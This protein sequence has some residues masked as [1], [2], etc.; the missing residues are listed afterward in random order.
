MTRD[1]SLFYITNP[2]GRVSLAHATEVFNSVRY[3]HT[4]EHPEDGERFVTFTLWD[5]DNL[6]N[7]D[8]SFAARAEITVV[9]VND[10]PVAM[11]DGEVLVAPG[12]AHLL[13][14]IAN[15]IDVDLHGVSIVGVPTASQGTVVVQSDSTLVYTP[16]ASFSGTDTITYTIQD[17]VGATSSA[18]LVV[19]DSA[20]N[21]APS[22]GLDQTVPGLEESPAGTVVAALGASDPDAADALIYRIVQDTS[23]GLFDLSGDDLVVRS[24]RT[25]PNFD[26][27]GNRTWQ[28]TV[29]VTDPQADADVS[30]ITI[31]LVDVFEESFGTN[32]G[33]VI[34]DLGDAGDTIIGLNGDDVIT[35]E[36]GDNIIHGDS[37]VVV[38]IDTLE[39]PEHATEGTVL[40]TLSAS[41]ATGDVTFSLLNDPLGLFDVDGD[42]LVVAAGAVLPNLDVQ[43]GFVR[44]TV[45]ATD[46]V[47]THSGSFVGTLL[48][49]FEVN[50]GTD[51]NNTIRDL[52]NAGDTVEGL[53]GNDNLTGDAGDGI[54]DGGN[55][56]DVIRGGVGADTLLGG[57][58]NDLIFVDED[59]V[60]V[61][62]GVG[63]DTL[64][65]NVNSR[66]VDW[67]TT[68][69]LNFERF[70]GSAYADTIDDSGDAT[71]DW[72]YGFDGEDT[73]TGGAGNDR[74]W[75]YD[76]NDTLDGGAGNDD[77]RGLHGDDV[78]VGGD[79]NDVLRGGHGA[80]EFDGGPGN[81]TIADYHLQ[82]DISLDAGPGVDTLTFD[83]ASVVG[84]L[85][86]DALQVESINA[87]DITTD[88]VF[89]GSAV[90]G[91]R[92][93][94]N[95]GQGN[96]TLIGSVL[97]D[98]LRGRD[99]DD[100][101]QGGDGADTLEG[102]RGAD[103]LIGG[104]GNDALWSDSSDILIDGGEG[105]DIL[106][107][108]PQSGNV[109]IDLGASG[110]E[111]I[112]N[113]VSV[114]DRGPGNDT[115]DA[116][117]AAV[118]TDIYA[119]WGD[120][121]LIG[122][123]FN[124]VL[125]GQDGDDTIVGGPGNDTIVGAEGADA[126]SGGI[127]NDRF[128]TVNIKEGDT[129]NGGD[130]TD[131]VV[132]AIQTDD[133]TVDFS[134]MEVEVIETGGVGDD[135][136][137]A[138]GKT[139]IRVNVGNAGTGEDTF[140]GSELND[141]FQGR[142]DNDLIEGNGGGDNL[143]GQGGDDILRG[144]DG[145]DILYGDNVV[146]T[147]IHHVAGDDI[148]E[149]G[150]GNDSLIGGAG[151]DQLIGGAGNDTHLGADGNDTS[152]FSGPI[153]DYSFAV[154]GND[155]RVTDS[156]SARDGVDAVEMY[157]VENLQFSD[158]LVTPSDV[159]DMRFDNIAVSELA[160]VGDSAG[161]VT[162]NT[163]LTGTPVWSLTN[164]GGGRFAIDDASGELS[165]VDDS[166]L[167]AE[168]L[169]GLRNGNPL[170][171][172][173]VQV[174]DGTS[175]VSQRI[176]VRFTDV[177]E[178]IEGGS[179]VD[180]LVDRGNAG[181]T[182]RGF[183]GNDDLRGDFG[184]NLIEGGDGADR[185]FGLAGDDTV[186]GD[187]GNDDVFGH[188]GNDTL[189]G[190]TGS[191]DL[192]GHDGNDTLDGGEG[193]DT[194]TGGSGADVFIGG[195]GDDTV[196]DFNPDAGDTVSMGDGI[197]TLIYDRSHASI[198][199]DQ[200]MFTDVENARGTRNDDTLDWS[201]QTTTRTLMY[202]Y[203]GNDTLTGTDFNATDQLFGGEGDDTIFAGAGNDIL[204]GG[205]SGAL[206]SGDDVLH[207]EDGND[208]IH[209][210]AGDDLLFGGPGADT[211]NG[212][213]GN[214]N[215]D[216]GADNDNLYGHAGS[217]S[218]SGGDGDDIIRDYQ[219]GIDKGANGVGVASDL[220]GG[221]GVDRLI[222]QVDTEVD[223]TLDL[224][225]HSIERVDSQGGNDVLDG[226]AV[227]TNNITL[228][229]NDG[230]DTLVG[231]QL[232]DVLDGGDDNDTITGGDGN[233]TITGGHGADSLDGGNGND[234]FIN[235]DNTDILLDGGAGFDWLRVDPRSGDVVVDMTAQGIEQVETGHG[236]R[237]DDVY[238]ATGKI[239]FDIRV[240]AGWGDDTVIGGALNDV[241][242]GEE[243]DDSLTGG[244]GN[245]ILNGG[246]GK[247]S[248]IGGAGNDT[249]QDL[250]SEDT[251]IDLGDGIDTVVVA[252]DSDAVNVDLTAT[253]IER[254]TGSINDDVFD[255]SAKT[256][257]LILTGHYGDDV[258]SGGS[259][260]DIII[261]SWGNDIVDGGDGIDEV[262][263]QGL[264][265]DYQITD[266]GNG[267][268]TVIDAVANRDGVNIVNN[269]ENIRFIAQNRVAP[270]ATAVTEITAEGD[271]QIFGGNG[272]DQLFGNGANDLLN[273]N[274]G[275]DFLTGGT[276]AD[277]HIGGGGFDTSIFTGDFVD[278]L[279][280]YNSDGTITVQDL[281][282]GRD[283]TDTVSCDVE[284]LQFADQ[285]VPTS[286]ICVD[287]SVITA[288]DAAPDAV[289]GV[290]LESDLV[291]QYN[292]PGLGE[293]LVSTFGVIG[294]TNID[295]FE[296]TTTNGPSL[297][298]FS[299]LDSAS[300]GS[301]LVVSS[302]IGTL[303]I[304]G[305][306]ATLSEVMYQYTLDA[307]QHHSGSGVQDLVTIAVTDLNG[308]VATG[309]LRFE[310]VD[311]D[312]DRDGISNFLD[313]DDDNDG[314]TDIEEFDV[315]EGS[316]LDAT[317]N[318]NS[319]A[320]LSIG[321][322]DVE[323]SNDG[324]INFQANSTGMLLNGGSATANQ[325]T[326]SFLNPVESFSLTIN[327]L[328]TSIESMG[329]FSVVPTSV[330]GEM[331]LIGSGA[332]T[333]V[334]GV[335]NNS[336]GVVTWDNLSGVSSITYTHRR[337]STGAGVF[338][339]DAS[340]SV[341][342]DSDNDGV[343]NH[344]D[345]DSDNDGITDNVEAQYT[346]SYVAPSGMGG[347]PAF[348]D[349]DQ[350]GLDG[351]YDAD[352][353][354]ADI[355]NGDFSDGLN[356]WN[357]SGVVT[358]LGTAPNQ[359]LV[360]NGGNLAA[361]GVVT[362]V[363]N[364]VVGET[365]DVGYDIFRNGS[366]TVSVTVE[367]V[368]TGNLAV[369]GS[370]AATTS[371]S[372][373]ATQ[374]FQFIAAST[375]TEIRIV[376]TTANSINVD[377]NIDNLTISNTTL[378][379]ANNLI[380][381][382][383]D[384][385]G[386]PDYLD[387]DS[388]G[389][390]VFDAVE[391]GHGVLQADIDLN[392]DADFDGL[393]DEVEGSNAADGFYVNDE[394]RDA[395]SI[396]LADSD[397]DLL[398]DGTN[399]VP[400][401]IDSDFREALDSDGDN[402]HDAQDMD[403]DNDGILDIVENTSSS[404]IVNP[405]AGER[406]DFML[407]GVAN[408]V[409]FS[410][411]NGG[412]LSSDSD[413]FAYAEGPPAVVG[414]TY[415]F[416]FDTPVDEVELAFAS[417][418]QD[419]PVGN[420]IVT[421]SDGVVVQNL[422]VSIAPL[423]TATGLP[424][425]NTVVKII[426][427]T[428][429][430]IT[431]SI[432]NNGTGNGAQGSG[433]ITL[434]G[435]DQSKTIESVSWDMLGDR[436]NTASGLVLPLVRTFTDSD[437]DG[438]PNFLDLDSDN[439]GI[440]DLNESGFTNVLADANND[441]TVSLAESGLFVGGAGDAVGVDGL[442]DVFA[443]TT[444]T[445]PRDSESTPDAIVD[446]VDLD[447]DGDSI[448]DATEARATGDYIAY[449]ATIDAAADTDRDGI[450]DVFDTNPLFGS[451]D[452]SFKS[453]TNTAYAHSD[454]TADTTPDY[455]DTDSDGDGIDDSIEA[456]TIATAPSFSDP[457]GSVN[458]P[459]TG[460]LRNTDSASDVDFRN[461]DA[462]NDGIPDSVEGTADTDGDGTPNYLDTDSDGD[463]IDD[464]IETIVDTDGDGLPDYLDLDSD[465]DGL[466]DFDEGI[467]DA[468][469]DG[470]A[471][472]LQPI[473][474]D[475]DGIGDIFDIDD[476]NDGILDV[477]E[478]DAGSLVVHHT[479][480]TRGD[481]MFNGV[482]NGVEFS[483]PNGGL[484]N[485]DSGFF[486]FREGTPASIGSIYEFA[487]DNPVDEVEL[488]F[489][490]SAE[491]AP[492]GNFTVTYSD[493]VV[494]PNLDV[495]VASLP[496]DSPLPAGDTFVKNVT[497]TTI[498][499]M[500][501]VPGND[502]TVFQQGSG[503]ITLRGLDPSKTI[504][505]ISWELLGVHSIGED[506]IV[507]PIVRSFVDSDADGVTDDRD[508]DSDNDGITDN[509]EA[510]LTAGYVAPSGVGGT[511]DFLDAN[512]DGLD[513][514][515][516]SAGT[517]AG[518]TPVDTDS[519]ASDADGI[520][521]YFDTDS[522]NDGIAD[523]VEAGVLAA[524][525]P[526]QLTNT[527][528]T[529][530]VDFRDLDTDNDGILDAVEGVLDTDGDGVSNYQDTDSDNDG[531]SDSI[532]GVND[533][534]L[535]GTPDYLDTDSDGDGIADVFEMNT[536]SDGD[537]TPDYL[538]TDSDN[539][540]INDIDEDVMSPTLLGTDSDNDGIDDA[541][542]VDVTGGTDADGNGIDDDFEPTDTDG[543]GT[544][545]HI[546]PDSDGDGIA[547][548]LEGT[549]D[550]DGDGT[551]DYL[552]TD[553]DNDGIADADEDTTSPILLGTDADNDGIDDAL[554]V[555][556]TG[557]T[558]AD[559]NGI[560]DALEPTD[561][562]ADGTPDHL[563]PDSDDDGIADIIEGSG[564]TDGDGIPDYLDSDSD[565]DGIS[566][567][568]EDTTSPTL[569]GTDA[570]NDGIDDAI[571]VD[572]TGGAD[573]DGNG[574]DDALEPTDTDGDGVPDHID[575][576]SDGDGIADIIEGV[577]DNDGDGI[578]D[579]LDSDSDNDG[580]ADAEEDSASPTLLGT[581]ADSDGIDD[582][583][584]VDLTGGTDA[585]GNGIDDDF[586]PTDTDGDGTPDHLDPD[587]DGDGIADIF[588]GGGDTDGDGTPDYQDTDSDNDGIAD[589]DEDVTSPTL[590]GADAD[591]DG[592]DDAI[593]VDV[594]GG[595]D[596]DGNGIDDVFEP[597]DSDGDGTPDHIDPDSD[598]DGIADI[599]EGAG[600]A[601]GDGILD[602]LDTDSDNDGIGDGDEDNTSPALLGTDA[603][604]DGIDDALDV[605][606]SGGVDA[607]GNGIDD[608]LE[609]TDT[610][611]D[612]IADHIDP[613]S[614][615]DGIADIFEGSGDTDG[616]GTPDYQDTDSDND[617]IVDADEDTT[618]PTLSGT[619][620]DNDGIDDAIDVDVTGGTDTDGNGIDDALEPTDTDGDGVPDYIDPD[621]DGDGIADI[622]EGN[623]DTDGDGIPDYLDND[624][625]NDGISDA[626]EDTTSPALLGTDAD[627]DG[628][629]DAIDVDVTGGTDADGNGI[630][631]ALE[632]TDTDGDGV[633]DHIDPDSDGDGIDDVVEGDV[634]TDGDGIRDSLDP[635]SDNDG[636][637]DVL[638]AALDTDNDGIPNYID[639][640]S[641]GDGLSDTLEAATDP[642]NPL[643]TDSDGIPDF[644]DPDSDNDGIPDVL[645]GMVDTD[646]DGIP[647]SQDLDV[648][649]DG[650]GD[651]LEAG[652]D[653][654]NPVDTD[655]DG[656]PD[657]RDL[658]SDG[659]G[660][661]D[662]QEASD[663][664]SDP[665]DS[666]GDGIRDFR[667]IDS[668]NDGLTDEEEIG[669]DPLNPLDSN[670]DGIPDFQEALIPEP[671][672]SDG[673]GIPDFVEGT[674]D[675]DGDGVPDA[676]DTD[677]DN[678]GLPD[679]LE[680]GH[681][682]SNPLDS[683]GDGIPDY[684]DLDSD[685][686][687]MT[688]LFEAGGVDAD[689]NGLIDDFIDT[690]G[691][692]GDDNP[693]ATPVIAW[694]SDGDGIADYLDLDS[695]NDGL[696]DVWESVGPSADLDLDG[697]LDNMIDSNGDG[698][699]DNVIVN[700]VRDTDNDGEPN[701]LDIDSD[702]DGLFDIVEAGGEDLN[703][704]G[705]VDAWTDSDEDG[706]PD[707]V[708]V[709][710]TGG[711]DQDGDGI[712]DFYDADFINEP[713]SDGDGIVD[714]FDEDRLGTGFTPFG[715]NDGL[716][717]GNLPDVDGNGIAD[718]L[719]PIKPELEAAVQDG[720]VLT[721]LNGHGCAINTGGSSKDPLIPLLAMFSGAVLLMRR[722][723]AVRPRA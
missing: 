466:S 88:S 679:S 303:S 627:N 529:D 652:P 677:S 614:D 195:L 152:V 288:T 589:A 242:L 57:A 636:V 277:T 692:G 44:F 238:D 178:I 314:I 498:G 5:F 593:D 446:Y 99:G 50:Q 48:D 95:S 613:D 624:S 584:D 667:D 477:V 287:V 154:V 206:G 633:P 105:T 381:V 481:F 245:D 586:E 478:N 150:P 33:E 616:D 658:D 275:N 229:G 278:Y 111:R 508:L 576:D 496:V 623:G 213:S 515:Y 16:D 494:V 334:V 698:L 128:T 176:Y 371:S 648:D 356:G 558:D 713:D 130:G 412:S 201:A 181:D 525:L 248:F 116:S 259:A 311:L 199:I 651:V 184:D 252:T 328:D 112:N 387:L 121:T 402:V 160:V 560:D 703:N 17:P 410:T 608:A 720:D 546:D 479:A 203:E 262:R 124:D 218:F 645:E 592:I 279:I 436:S 212:H 141:T 610:D 131:T 577:G 10:V 52:G 284:A 523:S 65:A 55:G 663:D 718:V 30:T 631:D 505:S 688:D 87:T 458:D 554:D 607:D 678:D 524:T 107:V 134:A 24:N 173:D 220:D 109:N 192:F 291:G 570:D 568:D 497:G 571:D 544:P 707:S 45:G 234:R 665:V 90:V 79:G 307:L 399:A 304:I 601:D 73:I 74:V 324:T 644:I 202:G 85:D 414:T 353:N 272:S 323:F 67:D 364:T 717:G 4:S 215:L 19:S 325:I 93:I 620:A 337:N 127:G 670:G 20:S 92:I 723:S 233:D 503:V 617:G 641:D 666:D 153:A 342:K 437:S 450:L 555:D 671:E 264:Q 377:L 122:G 230:N 216:G 634:D 139:D 714:S 397:F 77:I 425:G 317:I 191:D 94:V 11:N 579:Y 341:V 676:L 588:E 448:P 280:S 581:D 486:L 200:S 320:N 599:L 359:R 6:N 691:D 383:H 719:D 241:L 530:E 260:N 514:A 346:A 71:A 166:N 161:T 696:P 82:E 705:I 385:D 210:A 580:I 84:T 556:V 492:I 407:N 205:H 313:V 520:P 237:G 537:G 574:I 319:S 31:E 582:A 350:D 453:G 513:D 603:D 104:P 690:D 2:A 534:D 490:S 500:D 585:D 123:D 256:E 9:S 236:G 22:A 632:P 440:S 36:D 297:F 373:S 89:D 559:G 83:N 101:L 472:V 255:G 482:A 710:V 294:S 462:D 380:P 110:I 254:I 473:D 188:G 34:T 495:S 693:S 113:N 605:D 240:Y 439:D 25:L 13:D 474:L 78:L 595:A 257:S 649:G 499:V 351:V 480:G 182:L 376:D 418:I 701:H 427:G 267:N 522:D 517:A 102:D 635:D 142:D 96:D 226:S 12:V 509:V 179:S 91:S 694:D 81:D 687:G 506:V 392:N 100:V 540:G 430:G 468:N 75:G 409:E 391:A 253:G 146:T 527:D 331:A 443:A 308:V 37:N 548:I 460:D 721:G 647:D 58:G 223:F 354:V 47:A 286:S 186:R 557:G 347:T 224:A 196:I 246:E 417:I 553:S 168:I 312:H 622:V 362:T 378:V 542:D 61:D 28:V 330:S 516:D 296:L 451:D 547:D 384:K 340:V 222:V 629:D 438:V 27:I 566:D 435:L 268:Y 461:L 685:N 180:N 626:D 43:Q 512:A 572:V 597:T 114:Q 609:P 388:D 700:S 18:T 469:A 549:G 578:V 463:G 689:N 551:P 363:I 185:L 310:V 411:P 367:A 271:D 132:F 434:L 63:T 654:L 539:D 225:A 214:D 716:L 249:V 352:D 163:P 76:D 193:S 14:P 136:Y 118:G 709:D 155:L 174:T 62:G 217:D 590:L 660:L 251:A 404:I 135:V 157:T 106:V 702:G 70:E 441:G 485:V 231:S 21:S 133:L 630:D 243:G 167:D 115:Y 625:D 413:F 533:S 187:T 333:E 583:I 349:I 552:D 535:D 452:A 442:M 369:L 470:T 144:G 306:D 204:Y 538:D 406:G 683:D 656:T 98:I 69:F 526:S 615:G 686:D 208:T 86:M 269:A 467:A 428:T 345:L 602:Y 66:G 390:G 521:D 29:L 318:S 423:P 119:G 504:Q 662:A 164:D 682:P 289:E 258:M 604:N 398:T 300:I 171:F 471:D 401:N 465:S 227:L 270:L 672:D 298:T 386:V 49:V 708:D 565:N 519:G 145:N 209:A 673:D 265:T 285:T 7:R 149:G 561:T 120:D 408:G 528:G 53:N 699:A 35:G 697:V 483:S 403:D 250:H 475:G 126:M 228:L 628:I 338:F 23:A 420:F 266:N 360:F 207:G 148:L 156:D 488:A 281:A 564:D 459:L 569:L 322:S 172:V 263:V 449:P 706:L 1:G 295:T 659:D 40:A 643:D 575:P 489:S 531:I 189:E 274:A 273:G 536:D 396:A 484:V 657:Y 143:Q 190:G 348:V 42:N 518:L 235:Y 72:L 302:P 464:S 177:A 375:A 68:D 321:S 368:D 655:G 433:L 358:L 653:P 563:D 600:D 59:D 507:L 56:N 675:T 290:V 639:P 562:D 476:D 491:E 159:I 232:N 3:F 669:S 680:A 722:R 596:A 170:V 424:A 361:S 293:T 239:D 158:A 431:D 421:Y 309:N 97:N 444:G 541:L 355:E 335:I 343:P 336:T 344:L 379:T 339:V 598:G 357:A 26:A 457:D 487:F 315:S 137:D 38:L 147:F 198:S 543:D 501:S 283:G 594:T 619:D 545:D 80:D 261:M 684:L 8:R 221:D 394:N 41:G 642:L 416:T 15:D 301:P 282:F 661:T 646:G 117:T 276:G 305:Y 138:R 64:R 587:S 194:L 447:S 51:A 108:E 292:E 426:S 419:S 606:V 415:K 502:S 456:G 39:F 393:M 327:D 46:D 711:L 382:D 129:V 183:G 715:F 244:T 493:G 695:D 140:F 638:E 219:P 389:D 637:P 510:Q 664:P 299:D 573:T 454:D 326:I 169:T 247:D 165:V 422:D 103:S 511:V 211:L 621:S 365:Y 432:P 674:G 532:E 316:F 162:L 681:D 405:T 395:L 591:N 612:G 32:G 125:R 197:D 332:D 611:G 567:A 54:V 60:L 712:D 370:F 455:L 618:S 151:D 400:L 366:G 329:D 650:I 640:D 175:T 445:T 668:D 429:I 550:T 704:D 374:S 372:S